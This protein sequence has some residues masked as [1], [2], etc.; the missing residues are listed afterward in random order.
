M[1]NQDLTKTLEHQNDARVC[2]VSVLDNDT[3]NL[4]TSWPA[5]VQEL[6][7]IANSVIGQQQQ[8]LETASIIVSNLQQH[9]S[10][11][12]QMAA[13]ETQRKLLVEAEA[14]ANAEK[15][16]DSSAQQLSNLR[17]TLENDAR[18]SHSKIVNAREKQIKAEAEELHSASMKQEQQS[19]DRLQTQLQTAMLDI[20]K[21]RSDLDTS[22]SKYS[23]SEVVVLM[24]EENLAQVQTEL[25]K[26][27]ESLVSSEGLL[28]QSRQNRELLEK[29]FM[30]SL[31][32]ITNY[33]QQ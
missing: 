20:K 18:A 33:K 32:L 15:F 17:V 8:E 13:Q 24:L 30:I 16:L 4:S 28:A 31:T 22:I 5:C 12:Q 25:R 29:M 1:K 26:T 21:L 23:D 9:L 3:C 14:K 11:A 6:E 2:F 27:Q 10:H 7:A 19:F